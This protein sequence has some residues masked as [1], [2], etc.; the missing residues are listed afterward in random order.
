[1]IETILIYVLSV[2][3]LSVSGAI[4]ACSETELAFRRRIQVSGALLRQSQDGDA[5]YE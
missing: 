5:G 4:C 1:M 3:L 2:Y